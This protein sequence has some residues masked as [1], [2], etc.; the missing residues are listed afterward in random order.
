M[1][2]ITTATPN[3]SLRERMLQ[4]SGNLRKSHLLSSH[5]CIRKP[6][7]ADPSDLTKLPTPLIDQL[8]AWHVCP[9]SYLTS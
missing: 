5:P 7:E 8:A 6:A 1:N 3:G 2:T 4:E 9:Q